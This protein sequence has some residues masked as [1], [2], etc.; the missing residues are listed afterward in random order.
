MFTALLL[1]IYFIVFCFSSFAQNIINYKQNDKIK[2][3]TMPLDASVAYAKTFS[4]HS[5]A[6]AI[7]SLPTPVKATL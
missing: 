6:L 4:C 1:F 7:E 2:P 3:T 5:G